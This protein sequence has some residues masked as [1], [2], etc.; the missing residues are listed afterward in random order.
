MAAINNLHK[1]THYHRKRAGLTR[2]ELATIAGV[3]KTAIYDL[4]K[5]KLTMRWSTIMAILEAL[6]IKIE[7][8]SPLMEEF[9][10][11]QHDQ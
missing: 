8:S 5:G 10:K 4:E 3:G 9:L 11:I 7:L 1:I 6:N 2:N